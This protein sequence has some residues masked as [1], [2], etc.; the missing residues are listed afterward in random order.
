MNR[1]YTFP[2]S[3]VLERAAAGVPEF[4]CPDLTPYA[5]VLEGYLGDAQCDDILERVGR[6]EPY[7]VRGCGAVTRECAS[8][9]SLDIVESAARKL[10]DW[11]FRYDLNRGQHSW[12]QTYGPGDQYQRHMDASPGQRRKLTAVVM[13]SHPKEYE[14]GDLGLF[15]IPKEHTVPRTRGTIVVFQPWIEHAVSPVTSGLRQT[16]NMGFWGPPFK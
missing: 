3:V 12:L 4:M 13:L 11:Y 7:G 1:L 14:G 6:L 2:T 9:P 16:I 8:D 5:A 15:V 10:N